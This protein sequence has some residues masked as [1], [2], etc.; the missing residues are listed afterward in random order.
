MKAMPR[1][2]LLALAA[3]LFWITV[4]Y[5]QSDYPIMDRIAQKVVQKYQTSS[6]QQLKAERGRPPQGPQ[7]AM[8]QRAI[9]ML[10]Q[11]P[12]MR[13]AFLNKVAPPIANKMF[14]CGMIP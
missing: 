6:C 3:A 14:E 5:A 10:R 2:S 13:Q 8:E 4:A 9:Q 12:Q 1:I 11:D 7:A